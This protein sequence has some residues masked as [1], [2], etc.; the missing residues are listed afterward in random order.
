MR[1][2]ALSLL[3]TFAISVSAQADV[4]SMKECVSCLQ[5]TAN[6][7]CK[8][9]LGESISYCCPAKGSTSRSCNR[10]FCS[11]KALT[12]S[13]RFYTCPYEPRTC[14]SSTSKLIA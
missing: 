13:M 3:L 7:V 12:T 4:L 10:D 1:N 8:D 9:N 5:N 6:G 14:G 11:P 2:F